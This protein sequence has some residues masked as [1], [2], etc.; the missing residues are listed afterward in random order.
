MATPRFQLVE[1]DL[2]AVDLGPVLEVYSE[3]AITKR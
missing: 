3:G 2:S 1:G